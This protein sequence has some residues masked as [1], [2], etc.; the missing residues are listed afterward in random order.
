MRFRETLVGMLVLC[1][2][3]TSAASAV[4]A[5]TG[6]FSIVAYDAEAGEWGIAVASRVLA[7]GYIVPWAKAGVGA[8]ATPSVG[9]R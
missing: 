6:T 3:A 5:T 9:M 1:A 4:P 7:A 8:I 2:A